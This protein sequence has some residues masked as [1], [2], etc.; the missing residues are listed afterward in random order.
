MEKVSDFFAR[1][2]RI[3]MTTRTELLRTDIGRQSSDELQKIWNV[4]GYEQF[5]FH[6]SGFKRDDLRIGDTGRGSL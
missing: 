6:W 2:K 4:M 5:R 3:G 1:E